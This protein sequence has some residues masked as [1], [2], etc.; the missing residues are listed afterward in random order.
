[1][2]MK[3]L[4]SQIEYIKPPRNFVFD[5]LERSYYKFLSAHELI[6]APNIDNVAYNDYD[7]LILTGGPDS[8][9]RNKTDVGSHAGKAGRSHACCA[10][11]GRGLEGVTPSAVRIEPVPRRHP[12][13]P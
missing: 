11:S 2:V 3:I 4:I 6:P 7:C 13:S 5:A 12:C 1:M 8:V 10:K 9:A